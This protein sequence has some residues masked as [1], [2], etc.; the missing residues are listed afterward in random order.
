VAVVVAPL[1]AEIVTLLE[2]AT[3]FVVTVKVAV[4]FPEVTVTLAGTVATPVLLLERVTTVPADGAG[5]EIVTVPVEG[6]SP[7]TVVGFKVRELATGVWIVSVVVRLTPRLPVIVTLVFAVTGLLV[8]V[9]VA[10]VAPA[11][12]VTV[13]G[14]VVSV[15]LLVDRVTVAPPVGAGP[16]KV[17]VPVDD[18]PPITDVGLRVTELRVAAVTIRVAVLVTP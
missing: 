18:V 11:A 6:D 8:T 10:V 1:T 14:T 17:T 5:P 9:K 12:T 15:V 13:A 7:L 2:V 4:V 16:V 3:V